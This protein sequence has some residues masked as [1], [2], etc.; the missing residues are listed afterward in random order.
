MSGSSVSNTCSSGE[1]FILRF[2]FVL[3]MT[4]ST[5]RP[6]ENDPWTWMVVSHHC[7][8]GSELRG[9]GRAVS[10]KE[11]S[12]VRDT[13]EVIHSG[14]RFLPMEPL[15]GSGSVC[16]TVDWEGGLSPGP[17]WEGNG[18]RDGTRQVLFSGE[19]LSHSFVHSLAHSFICWSFYLFITSPLSIDCTLGPVWM[20]GVVCK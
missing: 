19:V 7:V 15:W 3:S 6:E 17:E 20:L 1:F 11:S 14:Q 18:I 8:L 2:I 16:S 4:W 12:L 9:S 13:E 10:W 5:Q